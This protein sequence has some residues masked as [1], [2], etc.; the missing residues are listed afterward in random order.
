MTATL[1]LPSTAVPVTAGVDEVATGP[2]TI[3]DVG[4]G[5]APSAVH[6]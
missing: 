5:Y 4:P 2:Q 1:V 3:E 6:W